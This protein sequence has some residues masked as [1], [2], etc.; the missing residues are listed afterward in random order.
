MVRRME[1]TT[2]EIVEES[3][4]EF[5]IAMGKRQIFALSKIIRQTKLKKEKYPELE[6]DNDFDDPF[7]FYRTE[8]PFIVAVLIDE[9]QKWYEIQKAWPESVMFRQQEDGSYLLTL[10]TASY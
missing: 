5:S 3:S 8:Y 2:K 1:T 7:P 4:Q 6:Q 9:H 10:K